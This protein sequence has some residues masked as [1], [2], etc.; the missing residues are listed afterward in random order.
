MGSV[1]HEL[2]RDALSEVTRHS[3]GAHIHSA[4][5]L[6]HALGSPAVHSAVCLQLVDV[7]EELKVVV[8]VLEELMSLEKLDYYM[9][10][11]MY[12]ECELLLFKQ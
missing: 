6:S 4:S 10:V 1:P 11:D 8:N 9:L 7:V 2:W 12:V 3:R 5:V